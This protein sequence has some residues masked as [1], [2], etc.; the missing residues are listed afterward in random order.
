MIKSIST[1]TVLSFVTMWLHDQVRF[2]MMFL[3]SLPLFLLDHMGNMLHSGVVGAIMAK[4]FALLLASGCIA[5]I[6]AGLV[7][8][9]QRQFVKIFMNIWWIVWLIYMVLMSIGPK[10][11]ML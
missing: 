3:E 4:G 9:V 1:L 2:I 10:A 8:L 5:L 11:L 6:I 7:W